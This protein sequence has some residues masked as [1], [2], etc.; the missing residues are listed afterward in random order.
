MR[1]D[2]EGSLEIKKKK[3]LMETPNVK[4]DKQERKHVWWN[5]NYERSWNYRTQDLKH[6][7]FVI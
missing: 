3:K 2:K 4:S 5:T 7:D 1:A 6:L